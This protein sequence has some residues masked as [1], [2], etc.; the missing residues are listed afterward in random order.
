[1]I[2]ILLEGYDIAVPWLYDE[3]KAYIKPSHKVAVIALSYR[4]NRVKS[5]EDWN[6]LYGKDNGRFYGGIVGGF[7]AYGISEDNMVFLNDFT[8]SRET[9]KRKIENADILY[10]LGGLPDRMLERIKELE[11][12]DTIVNHKGIIMGYSA[13]ALIQLSEYHLSPDE[14]YPEFSYYE[15]LGYL[16]DFYLEVHYEGTQIQDAAIRR[17][18]KERGKPVYATYLGDGALLVDNGNIKVLGKVAIYNGRP[19]M[20]WEAH[21]GEI[22]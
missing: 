6:V 8:D 5:L 16:N 11:L 3:L 4:D 12:Q 22:R 21:D 15:G 20:D 9:A 10:F 17:V 19:G 13:G 18:I 7:S 2:N 1:M 14:D